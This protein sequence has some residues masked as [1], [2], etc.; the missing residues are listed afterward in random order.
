MGFPSISLFILPN[1]ENWQRR[2]IWRQKKQCHQICHILDVPGKAV[3]TLIAKCKF[4]CAQFQA[5]W[6]FTVSLPVIIINSPRNKFPENAPKTMTH[7]D[8]AGLTMF[9]IGFICETFSDL[10][11]FS[12]RQD[13]QNRGKWCNDGNLS[14]RDYNNFYFLLILN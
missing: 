3:K 13:P 7:L 6:V 1:F 4:N 12:F 9:I 2:Q 10:Q 14:K 5:V 11:K 8:S